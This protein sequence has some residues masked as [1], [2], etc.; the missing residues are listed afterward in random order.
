MASDGIH[1]LDAD[2]LLIEA[3]EAFLNMLGHDHTAIGHLKVTDWDAQYSW[4]ELKARIDIL[5]AHPGNM[6]FTTRHC[7]RD[8]TYLDVEV[9]A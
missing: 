5:I 9:G 2:G 7:R 4:T 1:I 8:G 6:V 3:N